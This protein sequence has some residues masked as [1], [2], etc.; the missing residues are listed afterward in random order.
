[1]L[2]QILERKKRDPELKNTRGME[3]NTKMGNSNFVFF[4]TYVVSFLHLYNFTSVI[5]YRLL[6]IFIY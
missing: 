6:V 2:S 1:M 3:K 4:S 5:Q